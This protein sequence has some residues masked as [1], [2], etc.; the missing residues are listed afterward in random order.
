MLIIIDL[1][2]SLKMP[3]PFPVVDL[4]NYHDQEIQAMTLLA[5][6]HRVIKA[7]YP[8]LKALAI[9]GN[10]QAI[11]LRGEIRGDNHYDIPLTIMQRRGFYHDLLKSQTLNTK[12]EFDYIIEKLSC[13]LVDTNYF[14]S[15]YNTDIEG[16]VPIN[17]SFVNSIQLYENDSQIFSDFC[18]M[19]PPK[20]I[21]PFNLSD[22]EVRIATDSANSDAA[23]KVSM[24]WNGPVYAKADMLDY[25]LM[26]IVKS[27]LIVH[28]ALNKD[29]YSEDDIINLSKEYHYNNIRINCINNYCHQDGNLS[30]ESGYDSTHS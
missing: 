26:G 3:L 7:F 9:S 4:Y 30:D 10:D 2:L 12:A 27:Q 24:V 1:L 17:F 18:Q 28:R 16:V 8:Q 21:L 14:A 5:K 23:E 6:T 13:L 19:A 11:K 29:G 20:N 25:L 22:E 15:R